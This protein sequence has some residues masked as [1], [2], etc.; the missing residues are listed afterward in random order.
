[1][2]EPP[3]PSAA[4]ADGGPPRR[5]PWYRRTR[6][7]ARR[8]DADPRTVRIAR[9]LRTRLPGDE[10][11][12]DPLSIAGGEAP[13]LLGQRLALLRG[14][15]AS[16]VREAGFAALQVWQALGELQ[17]RGH[18]DRELAI[19][20]TD[21]V[22][23]SDW[24]LSAG[25]EQAVELLRLL[26]AAVEPCVTARGG[27]V[28]KRLGDGHMAVFPDAEEAVLAAH[29]ACEAVARIEVSGYAPQLRAGVHLGTPRRLGGDYL[30]V[31]VNIAARVEAAAGPGEVLIS[32]PVRERLHDEA[33][34]TVKRRWRL[35]AK[36]A[37]DGLRLYSV[38]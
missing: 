1:M 24:A 12:G 30:G 37:P 27:E 5:E 23:F 33:V 13:Q 8:A 26:A 4:D 11:Y 16:A 7:L 22:G 29:E 14:E 18:G 9:A 3:P 38:R 2:S 31:D 19:L 36:G 20:F 21:L 10:R 6:A 15:R 34:T 28:V 35:H 25:D 32:G 17:G